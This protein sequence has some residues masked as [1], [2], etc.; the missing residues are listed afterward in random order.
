MFVK[1]K[2]EGGKWMRPGSSQ[3]CAVIAQGAMA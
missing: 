3:W 2:R 1:I